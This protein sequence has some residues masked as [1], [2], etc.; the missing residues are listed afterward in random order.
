MENISNI[1]DDTTFSEVLD[2]SNHLT[3][4]SIGNTQ[5]NVDNVIQFAIE[6]RMELKKNECKEKN[7]QHTVVY[8]ELSPHYNVPGA[9]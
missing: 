6:E 8:K 9:S 5:W 7:V 2:I 3:G 1:M 4:R